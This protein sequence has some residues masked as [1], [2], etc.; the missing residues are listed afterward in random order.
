MI[1]PEIIKWIKRHAEVLVAAAVALAGIWLAFR[2]GWFFVALGALVIL[3]G[4]S[5]LIGAWRRLPFLRRIDAPGVVEFE[6]GAIR[7]Y[8]AATPGGE[9]ALPEL[10]EIRLMRL[11]GKGYWRLSD[12]H[13]QALLI[14]VDAAGADG[15][16]HAFTALEGL[17]MGRV[18][19]ALAHLEDQAEGAHI[20]WR[21]PD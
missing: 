20:L 13:G 12:K 10:T 1:R 2:G 17:E 9:V 19:S 14:P 8:D 7:Y 16:A 4:I 6:E 3:T 21:K 5:L 15:L 18:S 11:H